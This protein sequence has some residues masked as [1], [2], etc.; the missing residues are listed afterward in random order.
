EAL[1]FWN[2]ECDVVFQP[3]RQARETMR[4]LG[5]A[6]AAA[7]AEMHVAEALMDETPEDIWRRR[8]IRAYPD[9]QNRSNQK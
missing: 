1:I 8:L 4:M 9:L 6:S 5:R 7:R 2:A 3:M